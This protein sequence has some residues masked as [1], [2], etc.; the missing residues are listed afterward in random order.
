MAVFDQLRHLSAYLYDAHISGRHHLSDLY[1]LVQ[2]A[3]SIVP[4]LYLMITTGSVFL[5]VSRELA[6]AATAAAPVKQ[7]SAKGKD[8]VR[9]DSFDDKQLPPLRPTNPIHDVPPVKE[10]LKDMLDM[11]LGVQHPIRGLFL[12]YY[13][14]SMCRDYMPDG[15]G[16]NSMFGCRTDSIQFLLQNFVEMNKLWVRLQYIGHSREREQREMERRE[17]KLLIGSNLLRLSQLEGLTAVTF[18]NLILPSVMSEVVNCRD[19]LAQEYLMEVVIQVFPDDFHL[20]GLDLF[21]SAT[22]QLSRNV[23]I[24]GMVLS[25]VNRFTAFAQRA[26]ADHTVKQ[27][28]AFTSRKEKLPPISGI[29]DD[30][31]L[32][33]IFWDQVTQH[34]GMRPEFQLHD[35]ISLLTS[36]V[37]LSTGCYPTR[38][39]YVDLILGYAKDR[40]LQVVINKEPAMANPETAAALLNLQLTTLSAYKTNP[41]IFLTFP[42]STSNLFKHQGYSPGRQQSPAFEER[43]GLIMGGGSNQASSNSR[44]HSR[45]NS[46]EP[47]TQQYEFQSKPSKN[48]LGNFTD[49]LHLQPY[50]SRKK[51]A[52][53]FVELSISASNQL[54]KTATKFRIDTVEAV[55]AVFGEVLEVLVKDVIDGGLGGSKSLRVDDGS[56]PD[57]RVGT[58]VDVSA[59]F[60]PVNFDSVLKEGTAAAKVILIVGAVAG[61]ADDL[62][63]LSGVVR[64]YILEGGDIRMKFTIPAVVNS[65]VGIARDY[66]GSA[67]L[68]DLTIIQRLNT[69]FS[70]MTETISLLEDSEAQISPKEVVALTA[71][72]SLLPSTPTVALNLYLTVAQIANECRNSETCYEALAH[73][74][75]TYEDRVVDSKGQ[76]PCIMALIG[77]IRACATVVATVPYETLADKIVIHCGRLLKKVDQCKSLMICGHMYWAD[78]RKVWDGV[79]DHPVDEDVLAKE[80]IGVTDVGRPKKSKLKGLFGD[81]NDEK[82]EAVVAASERGKIWRD[83]RKVLDCLQKSLKVADSILETHVNTGLFVEILEQYIWFYESGNDYIE[84]KYLN[85]LIDL[86]N[87]NISNSSLSGS[88]NAIPEK[89]TRH[90]HNILLRLNALKDDEEEER[91]QLGLDQRITDP[92]AGDSEFAIESHDGGRWT[93]LELL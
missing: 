59:V 22:S 10:L 85:S 25:L 67:N 45:T 6:L 30:I 86:I 23:N 73:A 33:E 47:A 9:D 19:V 76:G 40:V 42:S 84:V 43:E 14:T 57:R 53:D 15:D 70:F 24:K 28:E 4:R 91:R 41:L 12:R 80:R 48:L 27:K 62:F 79:R 49:L 38:Y 71:V 81:N 50:I 87:T 37:E 83:G 11:T 54:A 35:V 77:G 46:F 55:D 18:T 52:Y 21:L 1:E 16:T 13:L 3:A 5:R 17:L 56:S 39:D 44:N 61:S 66:L 82:V 68:S 32:F 93:Y 89:V 74:I 90:F 75:A 72:R 20:H 29:P 51:V 31:R 63:E 60:T 69:L 8:P 65:C 88:S 92:Y 34:I 78:D 64:R 2:Y 36:L 58:V 7:I 26:R